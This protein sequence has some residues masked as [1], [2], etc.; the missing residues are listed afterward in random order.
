MN[1]SARRT[2]ESGALVVAVVDRTKVDSVA[3]VLRTTA[4]FLSHS[5]RRSEKIISARATAAA[6]PAAHSRATDYSSRHVAVVRHTPYQHVVLPSVH[7]SSAIPEPSIST[8]RTFQLVA[9]GVPKLWILQ[10]HIGCPYSPHDYLRDSRA[11][12]RIRRMSH[13]LIT[14]TDEEP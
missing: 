7:V 3:P 11:S 6:A 1:L 4:S 12:R 13:F 9:Q 8:A 14:S 5:S 10:E 2:N